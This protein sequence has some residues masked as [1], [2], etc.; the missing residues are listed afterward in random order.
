MALLGMADRPLLGG[1]AGTIGSLSAHTFRVAQVVIDV[2]RLLTMPMKESGKQCRH[3]QDC[4]Y[5]FKQ[6]SQ[7]HAY[8]GSQ[9]DCIIDAHNAHSTFLQHPPCKQVQLGSK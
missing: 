2:P 1:T 8:A 7:L 4:A 3:V 5:E 9:L 6:R